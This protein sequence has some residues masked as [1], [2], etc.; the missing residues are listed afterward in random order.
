M[1]EIL[2]YLQQCE[3]IMGGT[4]VLGIFDKMFY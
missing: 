2:F 1:S 3:D 4:L